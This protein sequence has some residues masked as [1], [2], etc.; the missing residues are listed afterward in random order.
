MNDIIDQ[1]N[2]IDVY[3]VFHPAAAQYRSFSAIHRIFSK[4]DYILD[5]KATLKKCKKTEI[6]LAYCLTTTQ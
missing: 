4:M 3:R 2:L 6:T 5:H 1:M